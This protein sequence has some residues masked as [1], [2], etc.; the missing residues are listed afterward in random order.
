MTDQT[1]RSAVSVSEFS[2]W[3]P[4]EASAPTMVEEPD[5]ERKSTG[6]VVLENVRNSSDGCEDGR[7]TQGPFERKEKL[8]A[9]DLFLCRSLGFCFQQVLTLLYV[10][11]MYALIYYVLNLDSIRRFSTATRSFT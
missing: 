5:V 7:N 3:T 9:L 4:K 10:G 2:K 6:K 1:P 8:S 11:M